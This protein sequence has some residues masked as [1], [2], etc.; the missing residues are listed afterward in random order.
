MK[1]FITGSR[2]YGE[3]REDSDTD[4]VV[5]CTTQEYG[6]LCN[7]GGEP[8]GS[9][10]MFDEFRRSIK[11]GPLNLICLTLEAE[12]EAWRKGTEECIAQKPVTRIEAVAAIGNLL[13]EI[14]IHYSEIAD[15]QLV[16]IDDEM[17]LDDS[18]A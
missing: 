12:F 11:F 18:P 9:S 5:L 16:T 1:C 10:G 8:Y 3:P 14:G 15:A 13:H 4:L 6:I 17:E 2:A 7:A